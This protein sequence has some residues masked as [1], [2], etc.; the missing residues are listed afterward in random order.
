MGYQILCRS[1]AL[2]VILT[3]SLSQRVSLNTT[4]HEKDFPHA[5]HFLLVRKVIR[6]WWSKRNSRPDL[7]RTAHT[8]YIHPQTAA[9]AVSYLG[10]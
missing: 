8:E 4:I 9:S 10:N 1:T 2:N 3:S 7:M 6:C 5:G